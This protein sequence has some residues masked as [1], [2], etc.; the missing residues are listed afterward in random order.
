MHDQTKSFFSQLSYSFGNEDW[1]TERQALKV[2]SGDRVF[3]ITAS[4]DRSLHVLLEDC[5]EVVSVDANSIQN[6]LMKLKSAAIAELEYDEY[7]SFL[8]GKHAHNRLETLRRIS[9][10][11]DK[12]AAGF[13]SKNSKMIEQGVLYQGAVERL[14]HKASLLVRLLRKQKVQRLF[15]MDNLE[16]QRQFVKK[17]WN[18]FWWKKFI[19]IGLNPLVSQLFIKDP[20]LYENLDPNIRVG[21]YIFKRMDAYLQR[22]LAK[23]SSLLS[24]I[25]KGK[26]SEEAYPP[27]LTKE[28]I[29]TIRG[30]LSR[31][32]PH[33]QD[34]V[35]YLES[36]QANSFDCFSL[37]DVAS[38][39]G[40][41]DFKRFV[42]GVYRAAKPG[43]RF[44][45]R[46]FLSSHKMPKELERYFQ[47]DY[48]L[49]E[50]LQQQDRCFVY[51]YM[52]GTITK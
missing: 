22:S 10:H 33:T 19:D 8:G 6:Y 36:A 2:R 40:P 11:L 39:L 24:L 7:H 21:D 31:I 49:E 47:R 26:V 1:E 15:A 44:S 41:E 38:Y 14:T 34:A 5:G 12:E 4:G 42:H 43:A 29:D 25:L 45:M 32:T 9:K 28:G 13:W 50:K 51:R 16:E 3:C 35:S 52:A 37:S 30:R 23:E 18:S 27:Y 17:H 48:A 20:G 46:Q